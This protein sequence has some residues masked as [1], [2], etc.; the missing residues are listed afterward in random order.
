MDT[1]S[2]APACSREGHYLHLLFVALCSEPIIA[3]HGS[4][5]LIAGR[6]RRSRIGVSALLLTLWE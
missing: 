5:N 2:E 4:R 6:H 1:D 3:A